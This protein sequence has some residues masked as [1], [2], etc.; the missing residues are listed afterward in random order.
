MA[1][2]RVH[3]DEVELADAEGE[4][5]RI[6]TDTRVRVDLLIVGGSIFVIRTRPNPS[7][8][9][10]SASA[11]PPQTTSTRSSVVRG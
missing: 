11:E 10:T 9:S 8:L 4:I 3:D 7:S 6:R 1:Q 5:L 2:A